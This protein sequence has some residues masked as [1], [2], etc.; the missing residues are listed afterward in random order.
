MWEKFHRH[1]CSNNSVKNK[2]TE[3]LC[4]TLLFDY[5]GKKYIEWVKAV[6][7]ILALKCDIS[8]YHVSKINR[9]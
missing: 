7:P 4:T 9:F 3:K 1:S 6:E 5:L 8:E 2:F